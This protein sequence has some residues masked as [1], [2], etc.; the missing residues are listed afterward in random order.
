[1]LLQR[2]KRERKGKGN[3]L[4]PHYLF[5]NTCD[6]Y[7]DIHDLSCSD[8]NVPIW[9]ATV[10]VHLSFIRVLTPSTGP[11]HS[12]YAFS[13]GASAHRLTFSCVS[14]LASNQSISN[15]YLFSLFHLKILFKF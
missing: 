8:S 5:T 9:A 2:L 15:I 1:M 6:V 10:S 13:L 11:Y 12:P 7:S 14:P 3:K 4:K